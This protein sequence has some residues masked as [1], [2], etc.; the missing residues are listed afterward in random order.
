MQVRTMRIIDELERHRP[1]GVYSGALGFFSIDGAADLSVVIRTAIVDSSG[2]TVGAGGAITV[3][4]NPQGEWQEL[5]LKAT[6]LMA[7]IAKCMRGNP[8]AYA[9]D[10]RTRTTFGEGE[11][12]PSGTRCLLA[13]PS[14]MPPPPALVET[15]LH[16]PSHGFFLWQEHVR[17]LA[18]SASALGFPDPPL[19]LVDDDVEVS[20][21][22][23]GEQAAALEAALGARLLAELQSHAVDWQ[24]S[25]ASRVRLTYS[26]DGSVG[27]SCAPLA[28]GALPL[29]T[30]DL[31]ALMT[32]PVCVARLDTEAV[33]SSDA[34][35]VHKSESRGVY[36]SARRRVGVG[37]SGARMPPYLDVL[38]YA[39][40]LLPPPQVASPC[41]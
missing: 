26:A 35:L 40:P 9:L 25:E 28:D 12:V 23:P 20:V 38:M 6:P 17:R 21:T 41:R 15:L 31:A 11:G 7:A 13:S 1:R 36:D 10:A 30:L 27:V 33:S 32:A 34:R 8:H 24:R 5:M 29:T 3:L 16:A 22:A 37:I 2:V 39:A 19:T 18:A 4:S 14:P